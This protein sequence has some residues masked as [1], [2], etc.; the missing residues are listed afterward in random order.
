MAVPGS[1]LS[2]AIPHLPNETISHILS[3][4]ELPSRVPPFQSSLYQCS[5]VNKDWGYLS[6]VSIFSA[7][8][9]NT[10]ASVDNLLSILRTC[11]HIPGFVRTLFL[12]ISIENECHVY[13]LL[14]Y[15]PAVQRLI[16]R[17]DTANDW[18]SL[19]SSWPSPM[20][21]SLVQNTFPF[22]RHMELDGIDEVPF[23]LL[24]SQC[25]CLISLRCLD[26]TTSSKVVAAEG[27]KTVTE[28]CL[29]ALDLGLSDAA[30]L[31]HPESSF[32]QIMVQGQVTITNIKLLDESK[33]LSLV[34]DHFGRSIVSLKIT[35]SDGMEN[36]RYPHCLQS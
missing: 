26:G 21:T 20:V 29:N 7:V 19:D 10:K 22:L 32:F 17:G 36:S 13:L 1:T 2:R 16:L 6:Q 4:I 25:P 5:L 12:D 23:V 3:Y 30:H 35:F 15:L 28:S 18:W 8:A 14:P 33:I 11:P 9:P 31:F 27:P 34:G 24:V